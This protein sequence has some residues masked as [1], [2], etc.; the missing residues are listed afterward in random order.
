MPSDSGSA[1]PEGEAGYERLADAVSDGSYLE[2]TSE[3]LRKHN[4]LW[5]HDESFVITRRRG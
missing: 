4:G 1:C 5:F 3:V 2:A